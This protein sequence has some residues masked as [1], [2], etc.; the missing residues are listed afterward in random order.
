MG[1][2]LGSEFKFYIDGSVAAHCENF[3]KSN[4]KGIVEITS[5]SSAGNWRDYKPTGLKGSTVD[6]SGLQVRPGSV[7]SGEKSFDEILNDFYDN[8]VSIGGM[9]KA[10][11]ASGSYYDTFSMFITNLDE[12]YGSMEDKV[13]YSGK[14]QIT[15]PITRT[16]VA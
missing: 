15:G 1:I 14:A 4:E 13:T 12:D 3:S 9:I 16:T 11:D 8:D 7:P 6:F 10:P 2:Y 5:R